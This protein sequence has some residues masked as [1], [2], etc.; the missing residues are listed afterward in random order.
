M[1]VGRCLVAALGVWVVR[2][3]MNW[4]YYTQVVGSHWEEIAAAY[5]DAFRQVIP[6]YITLDL[7]FA[8]VLV[9]LFAKAGDAL[10][11]GVKG[12]VTLA[13]I[14]AVVGAVSCGFGYYFSV[15]YLS[16]GLTIQNSVYEIVAHAVQGVVAAKLYKS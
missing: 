15:T 3:A 2:V 11:G 9:Y 14:V 13:V 6:G 12:G 4:T 7:V 8:L 16:L 1:N 5:P 10:G